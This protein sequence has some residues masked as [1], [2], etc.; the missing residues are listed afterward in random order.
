MIPIDDEWIPLKDTWARLLLV[1][2]YIVQQ[3]YHFK[4]Y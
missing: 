2:H 3:T 1:R 4:I